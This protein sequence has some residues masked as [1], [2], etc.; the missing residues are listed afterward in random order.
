MFEA[1]C[2][3][4]LLT[5]LLCTDQSCADAMETPWRR[6]GDAMVTVVLLISPGT[7]AAEGARAPVTLHDAPNTTHTYTTDTYTQAN[8]TLIISYTI[9]KHTH[10][11]THSLSNTHMHTLHYV[12]IYICAHR[13]THKSDFIISLTHLQHIPDQIIHSNETC[14][15]TYFCPADNVSGR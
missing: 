1:L 8:H 9:H 10:H 13:H 6:R 4:K 15:C 7:P 5:L 11:H 12:Y 3:V 14:I 2:G